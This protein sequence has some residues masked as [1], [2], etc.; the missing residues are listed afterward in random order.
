M[1]RIL[2]ALKQFF[3]KFIPKHVEFGFVIWKFFIEINGLYCKRVLEF[4]FQNLEKG[5]DGYI[6]GSIPQNL[7]MWFYAFFHKKQHGFHVYICGS[8]PRFWSMWFYAFFQKKQYGFYGFMCGSR[9]TIYSTRFYAFSWKKQ[10]GSDGR[11]IFTSYII[12]VAV[13]LIR[14]CIQIFC[15]ELC[16]LAILLKLYEIGLIEKVKKGICDVCQKI[17]CCMICWNKNKQINLFVVFSETK[18]LTENM[19]SMQHDANT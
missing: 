5:I 14:I 1:Q 15:N 19:W 7:S 10:T 8:I 16:N 4:L 13:Y 12:S 11:H 18:P 17:I 6:S 9:P 3:C 2:F